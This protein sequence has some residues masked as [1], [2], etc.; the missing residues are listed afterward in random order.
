MIELHPSTSRKGSI[1]LF[2]AVPPGICWVQRLPGQCHQAHGTTVVL[3][4]LCIVPRNVRSAGI[5]QAAVFRRQLETGSRAIH[6]HQL[7]DDAQLDPKYLHPSPAPSSSGRV[8]GF[9]FLELV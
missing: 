9:P 3:P 6:I 7:I 1:G 2:M 5:D 8:V 4:R